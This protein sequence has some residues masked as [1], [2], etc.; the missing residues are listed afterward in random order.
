MDFSTSFMKKTAKPK[1]VTKKQVAANRKNAKKAGRPKGTVGS[2]R[3]IEMMFA[4]R[5]AERINEN[6]DQW[7]DAI[8]DLALGHNVAA[9]NKKGEIIKVYQEPPDAR[10]WEKAMNRAFGRPKETLDASVKHEGLIDALKNYEQEA[11][12]LKAKHGKRRS[13]KDS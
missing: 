2:K 10:A 12:K 4:A 7:L 9:T 5:L 13:K 11:D 1:K 3:K 8:T 6:A